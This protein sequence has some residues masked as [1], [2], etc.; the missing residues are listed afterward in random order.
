MSNRLVLATVFLVATLFGANFTML[1]F[2]FRGDL[3]T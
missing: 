2:A 3:M 1:K